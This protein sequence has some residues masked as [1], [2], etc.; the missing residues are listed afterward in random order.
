MD[1]KLELE[2]LVCRSNGVAHFCDKYSFDD[3]FTVQM[4]DFIGNP[5][6]YTVESFSE[7]SCE[8]GENSVTITFSG[9]NDLPGTEVV[10]FVSCDD[11]G[12][13]LWNIKATPGRDYFKTEWIDFPRLELRKNSD[14]K[15]LIPNAEGT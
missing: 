7:N 14:T 6:S 13:L 5:Y 11:N 10:I 12:T 1:Y 15:F 4:R 8:T 2:K 9:C 3:L